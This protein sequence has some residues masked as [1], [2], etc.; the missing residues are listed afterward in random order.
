LEHLR[1]IGVELQMVST[2]SAVDIR[3]SDFMAIHPAFKGEPIETIKAHLLP[4][5]VAALDELS[6][7]ANATVAARVVA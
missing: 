2:R 4:A 7:W 1:R 6:W 3:G 5:A